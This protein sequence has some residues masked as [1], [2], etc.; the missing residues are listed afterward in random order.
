LKG[1]LVTMKA[2]D[3]KMNNSTPQQSPAL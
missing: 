3:K 1:K 2:K